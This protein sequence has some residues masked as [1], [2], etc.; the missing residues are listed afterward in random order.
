VSGGCASYSQE[1]EEFRLRYGAGEFSRRGGRA[2]RAIRG[3]D[4]H[5][6]NELLQQP[7]TLARAEDV[8]DGNGHLLLLEKGMTRL[9]QGDPGRLHRAV[10][11]RA[12]RARS[13]ATR[14]ARS[15][16]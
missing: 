14:P 5:F 10:A 9:G 1:L 12:R 8:A 11:P 2:R 4:R 13:R 6:A 16:P 15:K 7:K 3:R